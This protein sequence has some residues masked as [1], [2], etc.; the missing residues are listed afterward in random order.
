MLAGDI[1]KR[2]VQSIDADES[3][4]AAAQIMRNANV[5]FLPVCEQGRVIGTLTDRDIAIRGVAAGLT[6]ACVATVMTPEVVTCT[7]SESV[8]A[9]EERMHEHR[10]GR[11]VC[12]NDERA[13][14]GVITMGDVL[15][16]FDNNTSHPSLS[17]EYDPYGAHAD[18]GIRH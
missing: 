6:E 9:I 2:A 8:A 11:I 1:M 18:A 5:G 15:E 10:V 12:V 16:F 17:H 14:I 3:L 4:Q 7:A 13:P